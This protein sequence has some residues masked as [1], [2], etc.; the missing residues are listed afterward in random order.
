MQSASFGSPVQ[1]EQGSEYTLRQ[2][3]H[4]SFARSRPKSST[5][6]R[7]HGAG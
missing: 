7:L 1:D 4:L 2:I 6:S 5:C 3:A